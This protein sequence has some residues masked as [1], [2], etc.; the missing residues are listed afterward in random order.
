VQLRIVD[1]VRHPLALARNGNGDLLLI[2][3]V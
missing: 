1:G 2:L 3:T